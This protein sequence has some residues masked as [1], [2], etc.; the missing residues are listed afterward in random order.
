MIACGFNLLERGSIMSRILQGM[1]FALVAVASSLFVSEVL[2]APPVRF[3]ITF[4]SGGVRVGIGNAPMYGRGYYGPGYGPVYGPVYGYRGYGLPPVVIAPR[5][6]Y[7]PQPVYV[8][9]QPGYFQPQPQYVPA[10]AGSYVVPSNPLSRPDLG[11]ITLFSPSSNS[12]DVP[13]TL[14]GHPYS[15]RPGTKQKFTNDRTWTIE[16]ESTPGQLVRYTLVSARYKFKLTDT[17]LGLFQTQ[18]LPDVA[19]PGLPPA[20]VPNPPE[21]SATG[22]TVIPSRPLLNA[23]P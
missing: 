20:P 13:Y 9:P 10:P 5:P 6:V 4:G 1:V 18:D 15:M 8:S 11:E 22:T 21:E 19:Q 12:F 17:G 23:T 3:G 2:A 14:N 16:F 7:V